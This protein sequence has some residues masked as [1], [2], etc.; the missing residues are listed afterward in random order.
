MA[1]VQLRITP[2][3]SSIVKAQ[4]SDWFVLDREL[5]TGAT[6]GD[7][8]AD[9]ALRYSDFRQVVFNPDTGEVGDQVMVV[10][11]DS[12]L[13]NPDITETSLNEGD[14]ITLIPMYTGG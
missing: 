11:N 3:L 10:L 4:G 14:C 1:R 5:A 8:L 13:Q 7:F 6:I 12:L 2:S 9:L